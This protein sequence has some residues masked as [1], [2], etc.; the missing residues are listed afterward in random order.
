[1]VLA[2]KV[3]AV[4]ELGSNAAATCRSEQGS[5]SG[6]ERLETSLPQMGTKHQSTQAV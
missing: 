6:W 1:M 3:D 5:A 2:V 4:A